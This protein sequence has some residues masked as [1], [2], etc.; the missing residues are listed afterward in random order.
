[1]LAPL[2]L[3]EAEEGTVVELLLSYTNDRSS[4][5]KTMSM[6][7]LADIALRSRR[8]AAGDQAAYRRTFRYR[9]SSH[10]GTRQEAA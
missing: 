9:Y 5:V 6:Q 3:T 7:A 10:E 8:W 4:I 2:P 1:M